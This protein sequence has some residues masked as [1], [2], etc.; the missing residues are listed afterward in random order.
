MLLNV[1]L[2]RGVITSSAVRVQW[3][4]DSLAYNSR[5]R[6][7]REVP[8]RNRVKRGATL[9]LKHGRGSN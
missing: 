4:K 9:E 2:V 3:S 1:L 8:A 6:F 5:A 7:R